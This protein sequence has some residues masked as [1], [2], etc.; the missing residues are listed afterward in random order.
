[1]VWYGMGTEALDRT[2]LLLEDFSLYRISVI[3]SIQN[4]EVELTLPSLQYTILRSCVATDL[5][6]TQLQSD[7]S[8]VDGRVKSIQR[9][10]AIKP[11]HMKHVGKQS[12]KVPI[13]SAEE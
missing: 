7:L 2:T 13:N 5:G 12:L 11:R 9:L 3:T 6:S 1:M 10:I 8:Q 4:S